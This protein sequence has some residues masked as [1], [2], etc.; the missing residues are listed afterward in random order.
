M[1]HKALFCQQLLRRHQCR[2]ALPPEPASHAP[3]RVDR[4]VECSRQWTGG[5]AR[6]DS[7]KNSEAFGGSFLRVLSRLA[8]NLYYV[9]A[10]TNHFSCAVGLEVLSAGISVRP[11]SQLESRSS[12][13]HCQFVPRL[14]PAE[15][16]SRRPGED[17]HGPG[18]ARIPGPWTLSTLPVTRIIMLTVVLLVS[19]LQL[20]AT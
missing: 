14:G 19:I 8:E 5:R 10:S 15:P 9:P 3:S 1:N 16:R 6:C 17:P 7:G 2:H 20:E 12:C 18:W 4:A 13:H 11:A